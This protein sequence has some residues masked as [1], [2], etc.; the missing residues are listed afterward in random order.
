MSDGDKG[1][2]IRRI[3]QIIA[4]SLAYKG[5]IQATGYEWARQIYA[6]SRYGQY[7]SPD[8][9][10]ILPG[11]D[12]DSAR[13]SFEHFISDQSIPPDTLLSPVIKEGVDLHGKKC[14]YQIIPKILFP[15]LRDPLTAARAKTDKGYMSR[16]AAL[17]TEQIKGRSTRSKSDWSITYMLDDNWDAPWFRKVA[18]FSKSFRRCVRKIESVKAATSLYGSL[19]R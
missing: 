3:D 16:M 14:R 13:Q 17:S 19:D 5:T 8:E 7:A 4:E 1:V 2:L 9:R 15:D 11:I 18:P 6:R 10:V 12:R